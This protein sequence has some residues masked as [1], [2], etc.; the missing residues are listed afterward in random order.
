MLS[1]PELIL[2]RRGLY[3]FAQRTLPLLL[4]SVSNSPL[5]PTLLLSGATASIKGSAQFGSFAAGKF[6][7]RALGQ[8]LAREFGPQGVHVAH[9]I[10]DGVIDIPRTKHYNVNEGKEDGKIDPKAV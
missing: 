9:I 8:S 3:T 5:P 1:E 6:A 4:E 7:L 2:S 10:L